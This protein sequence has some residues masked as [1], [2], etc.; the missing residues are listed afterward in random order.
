MNLR[1]GLAFGARRGG[2][3]RSSDELAVAWTRGLPFLFAFETN[4]LCINSRNQAQ[5]TYAQP[6]ENSRRG[7]KDAAARLRP[8]LEN[9]RG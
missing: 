5:P 2:E 7:R 1:S 9:A 6:N 4:Y 8:G 3:R